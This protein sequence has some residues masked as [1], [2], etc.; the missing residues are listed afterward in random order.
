MSGFRRNFGARGFWEEEDEPIHYNESIGSFNNTG[1]GQQ[2]I[3]G[4]KNT[5]YKSG[6]GNGMYNRNHFGNM[7]NNDGFMNSGTQHIG[8]LINNT[9]QT[10]GNGNGSVVFG[11]FDS[12]RNTKWF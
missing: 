9:G 1:R 4:L 7:V 3:S 2:N 5:G 11:G 6:D 8:G 12:S 10:N